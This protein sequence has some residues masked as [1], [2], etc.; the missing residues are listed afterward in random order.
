MRSCSVVEVGLDDRGRSVVHTLRCES[1]LLARVDGAGDG[2]TVLLLGGA[3]GPLGGDDLHLMLRVGAGASVSVRSVAA[4]LAQPGAGGQPSV[5]RT[6]VEVGAGATLDWATQPIISVVG[7]DHRSI[8]T[9][10]AAADAQV[11][12][13]ESVLLGRHDEKPGRLALRQR[14]EVAGGV[15]LDHDVVLGVGG[16]A[17]PGAHGEV[18]WMQSEVVLGDAA[19][20]EPASS[21]QPDLVAGVFPLA[22]G[23]SLSTSAG[24]SA[25]TFPRT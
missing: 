3:A 11:R 1:P 18:R 14:V 7:S 20:T 2:L 17:G 9:V 6:V 22:S 16:P 13:A 8:T 10:R 19:A 5:L 12:M 21:V 23:A 25:S 24:T 4:M 15:V